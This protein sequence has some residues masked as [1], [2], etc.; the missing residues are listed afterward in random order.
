M[1]KAK[2]AA[3]ATTLLETLQ[4]FQII[5]VVIS[6]ILAA[7]T[8]SKAVIDSVSAAKK[9]LRDQISSEEQFYQNAADR[10]V[11]AASAPGPVGAGARVVEQSYRAM[12][13]RPLPKY[14]QT[15]FPDT[16]EDGLSRVC[17]ARQTAVSIYYSISDDAQQKALQDI[18]AEAQVAVRSPIALFTQQCPAITKARD[19]KAQ[20]QFRDAAAAAPAQ[21][22]AQGQTQ[23]QTPAGQPPQPSMP[24]S[25]Q[26]RI[27]ALAEGLTSNDIR[28]M[29]N[30]KAPNIAKGWQVDV[31]YCG[32]DTDAGP[33]Y[34]AA[35]AVATQLAA[36]ADS[37]T[38]RAGETLGLIRLR[39]IT[40][41][42]IRSNA[43]VYDP[44]ELKFATG[45][46]AVAADAAKAV[47]PPRTFALTPNPPDQ[48]PSDW[49]VSLFSCTPPA[50]SPHTRT[51]P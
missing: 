46:A 49:Y 40:D 4:R 48:K 50:S 24:A 41:K 26:A 30:Q 22:Q 37:K 31:Y 27:D 6:G 47:A 17:I 13:A 10:A 21:A 15:F 39:A 18:E 23:A 33:D 14:D 9:D 19:Q 29:V 12:I 51:S 25:E 8:I 11:K 16:T 36:A 45:L 1:L 42:G 20:D 34:Q 2:S 35:R 43:L 7:S 28:G 44:S 5:G 38:K 32:P 3:T